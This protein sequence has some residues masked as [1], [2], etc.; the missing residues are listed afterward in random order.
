[1]VVNLLNAIKKE[2]VT[3]ELDKMSWKGGKQYFFS[4]REAYEVL[5]LRSDIVLLVEG[6]WVSCVLTKTTF[7]V[8][9][10]A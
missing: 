6:V 7:F 8:W 10:A 3:V 2:K 5:Q 1:M 4:V 9:E